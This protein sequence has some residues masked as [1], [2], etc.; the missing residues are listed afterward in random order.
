M[1]FQFRSATSEDYEAFCDLSASV[2]RLHR[3]NLPDF[4]QEPS[5]PVRERK[6]FQELLAR[7]DV[8]IFIA[9]QD[10]K[11]VGYVHIFVQETPSIP[12]LKQRKFGV[13]DAIVVDEAFRGQGVGKKLMDR[14]ESWA[15]EQGA[16]SMELNVYTFNQEALDFYQRIGY[17]SL[18]TRMSK[19]IPR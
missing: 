15:R 8:Q 1:N 4:F 12:L 5:G 2:D 13:I 17:R 10:Q 3:E 6:Y 16:T 7:N 11:I 19:E 9:A 18:R 14:A